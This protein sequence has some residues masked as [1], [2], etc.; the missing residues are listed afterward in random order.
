[1]KFTYEGTF[2]VGGKTNETYRN[3]FDQIF[4]KKDTVAPTTSAE[5]S[6]DTESKSS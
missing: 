1:M 6:K 5:P 4:R 2:K 3:N